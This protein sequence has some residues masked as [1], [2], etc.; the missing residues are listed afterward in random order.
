MTA[1]LMQEKWFIFLTEERKIRLPKKK[2]LQWSDPILYFIMIPV[3]TLTILQE[4]NQEDERWKR[5]GWIHWFVNWFKVR[6]TLEMWNSTGPNFTEKDGYHTR[7]FA[8]TFWWSMSLYGEHSVILRWFLTIVEI[9]LGQLKSELTLVCF[10]AQFKVI[11]LLR[12]KV[13]FFRTRN[14]TTITKMLQRH[15]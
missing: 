6:K 7:V 14:R 4:L 5:F 2:Y 12:F 1:L 3:R 8:D 15:F 9:V 10:R 11:R 13:K